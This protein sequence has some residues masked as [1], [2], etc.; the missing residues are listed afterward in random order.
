MAYQY[1]NK[2]AKPIRTV[3]SQ[4]DIQRFWDLVDKTPGQGPK[5]ECWEWKGAIYPHP[6]NMNGY[7]RLTVRRENL[8]AH[9]VAY[10]LGYG[11]NPNFQMVLHGCDNPPCCRPDHLALGDAKANRADMIKRMRLSKGMASYSAKR[12]PLGPERVKAIRK[13]WD[14]GIIAQRQ[15]A[16]IAGL[17]DKTVNDIIRRVSWNYPECIP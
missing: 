16:L 10:F 5:G 11:I 17:P 15:L 7:G 12:S 4:L 1:S 6:T 13:A 14:T 3:F 9:R 8:R 2:K